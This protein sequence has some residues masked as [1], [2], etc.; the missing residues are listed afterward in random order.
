MGKMQ[1]NLR[2]NFRDKNNNY[3][4]LHYLVYHDRVA[5][6]WSVKNKRHLD[7][8]LNIDKNLGLLTNIEKIILMDKKM[9]KRPLIN[10][11][12]YIGK[13]GEWHMKTFL[14]IFKIKFAEDMKHCEECHMASRCH[15][16][17]RDEKYQNCL[18]KLC[19]LFVIKNKLISETEIL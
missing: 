11:I 5:E 1:G 3:G 13:D 16:F 7:I 12:E 8:L 15:P 9:K 6:K 17:V 14:P 19:T 2:Y 18:H 10:H 4:P